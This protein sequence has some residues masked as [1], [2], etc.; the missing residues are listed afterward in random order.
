MLIYSCSRP[1]KPVADNIPITDSIS[2]KL[3]DISLIG[4]EF[5]NSL[6]IPNHKVTIE[7]TKRYNGFYLHRVSEPMEGYPVW[8]NT[9]SDTTFKIDSA[10]YTKLTMLVT[11][12]SPRDIESS[13]VSGDDGTDCKIS[14]GNSQN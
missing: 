6:I 12:I 1:G 10:L 3:N 11:R 5:E 9:K 4:F 7:I 14:Y 13:L 8:E 2:T